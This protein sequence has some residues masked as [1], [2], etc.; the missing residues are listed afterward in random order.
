MKVLCVVEPGRAPSTRLRLGDCIERYRKAGIEVSTVSARRSSLPERLHLIREAGR[1]DLVVLF[2]TT[3]FSALDLRLLL[4]R[5]P[6]IIFDYD[7][8]VMFREQK[9]ARPI[10]LREFEKFVRTVEHCAAVV[11]GNAFL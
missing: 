9:Y 6:R 1:H 3:G 2:K 8:A 7:D 5:N 10:R 4:R 11:A